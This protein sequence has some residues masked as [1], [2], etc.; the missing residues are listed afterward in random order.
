[1]KKLP[2]SFGIMRD[3]ENPLWDKY[4]AWLQK[5]LDVKWNGESPEYYGISIHWLKGKKSPGCDI[6]DFDTILTLEQWDSIVNGWQPKNA[7][8]IEVIENYKWIKAEFIGMDGKL[9]VCCTK[10]GY[11]NYKEARPHNPLRE[12]IERLKARLKE[13]EG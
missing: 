7:E 8:E 6:T 11:R 5:K 12:E 10:E 4:I 3:A 1:M 13:L 2:E 9:F